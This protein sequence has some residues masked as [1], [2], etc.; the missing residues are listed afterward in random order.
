MRTNGCAEPE[1]HM[2]MRHARPL[3]DLLPRP[4]PPSAMLLVRTAVHAQLGKGFWA[5]GRC[6]MGTAH[7]GQGTLDSVTALLNRGQAPTDCQ[8]EVLLK[9]NAVLVLLPTGKVLVRHAKVAE[10]LMLQSIPVDYFDRSGLAASQAWTFIGDSYNLVS[11]CHMLLVLLRQ[12]LASP[13]L[14]PGSG[15]TILSL[16]G[17]IEVGPLAWLLLEEAGFLAP[18]GLWIKNLVL[19]DL[20]PEE[21]SDFR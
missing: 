20:L 9:A 14:Q 21:E 15:L 16:C 6:V 5:A 12:E 19:H 13:T 7:L 10:L 1:L 4:P 17:G 8:M 3:Y 18:R 2:R 11:Q